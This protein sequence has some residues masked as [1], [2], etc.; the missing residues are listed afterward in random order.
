MKSVFTEL[1]QQLGEYS[2]KVDDGTLTH[3]DFGQFQFLEP[4]IISAYKSG[5][6]HNIEYRVLTGAYYYIKD[7]ARE[8]LGLD[9]IYES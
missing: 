6:I 9:K 4:Q 5:H 7:G 8:V 3:D 2:E 1:L